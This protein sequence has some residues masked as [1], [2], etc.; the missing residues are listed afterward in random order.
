MTEYKDGFP[1]ERGLFKVKV[2]GKETYLVHHFCAN[3]CKHWWSDT[4]GFDV[5]GHEI[6][7]IDKKLTIEDIGR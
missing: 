2:D 6:K 5:V 3:N 7:F 1:N 4:S